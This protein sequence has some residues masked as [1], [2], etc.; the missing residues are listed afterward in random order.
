MP[1]SILSLVPAKLLNR[2]KAALRTFGSYF[3]DVLLSVQP[4]VSPETLCYN[5]TNHFIFSFFFFFP[6]LIVASTVFLLAQLVVI[7]IWTFLHQRRRKH[8]QFEGSPSIGQQP[9]QVGQSLPGSRTDSMCKLY[10][11]GY[12]GRNF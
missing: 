3:F 11:S 8:N 12:T 9:I 7:A 4:V 10:E 2:F 5:F 6:G 1:Y